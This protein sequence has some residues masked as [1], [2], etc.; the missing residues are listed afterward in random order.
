MFKAQQDAI[1]T[2]SNIKNKIN[3]MGKNMSVPQL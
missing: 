2:K 3:H 1:H